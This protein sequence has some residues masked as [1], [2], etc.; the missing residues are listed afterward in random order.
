MTPLGESA[1]ELPPLTQTAL[2]LVNAARAGQ[3][4]HGRSQVTSPAF[5][6]SCANC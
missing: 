5:G 3:D 2:E 4:P 1:M 6:G